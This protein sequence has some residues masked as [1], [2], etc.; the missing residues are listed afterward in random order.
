MKGFWSRRISSEHRLF[1]KYQEIKELTE[2]HHTS[3]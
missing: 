1:I 2:V 3:M